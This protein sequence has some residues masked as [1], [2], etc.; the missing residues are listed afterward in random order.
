MSSRNPF[1]PEYLRLRGSRPRTSDSLEQL[2]SERDH[3]HRI[4]VQKGL[5][6][7]PAARSS[8]GPSQEQLVA[9]RRAGELEAR[10][11][12]LAA[13]GYQSP[14]EPSRPPTLIEGLLAAAR[15]KKGQDDDKTDPNEVFWDRTLDKV[16]RQW[17]PYYPQ[18]EPDSD[19][20]NTK[21]SGSAASIQQALKTVD[22]DAMWSAALERARQGGTIRG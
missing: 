20:P 9:A 13:A 2:R 5:V 18:S 10:H 12:I 17:Q 3:W 19:P 16:R 4:A 15:A 14:S 11:R 7:R 21:G 1:P 6:A 8:S 22:A